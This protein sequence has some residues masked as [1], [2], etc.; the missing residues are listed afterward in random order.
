MKRIAVVLILLIAFIYGGAAFYFSDVIIHFHKRTLEEDRTNLKFQPVAAEFGLG[1]PEEASVTVPEHPGTDETI[2]LNGWYFAN[3][4]KCAVILHHGHTGTR[5]GGLKYVRL[6]AEAPY[7]CS[8]LTVDARYHGESEGSCGTYGYHESRDMKHWIDWLQAKTQLPK[9]QIGL[10]GESM[11]AAIV[12]ITAGREP[13]LA[14]VG[15]DAP[16]S[17]LQPIFYERG[18][19]DFGAAVVG[20]ILPP[21]MFLAGLRCNFQPA[22]VSP[23][24]A[25]AA[26]Q[27]P[28]F[29]SHS[30]ADA[31]T[32]PY[33]SEVIYEA[34]PHER[35]TLHINEWGARHGQDIFVNPAGYRENLHTFLQKYVPQFR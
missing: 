5:W 16:Y 12:L 30:L 17:D 31:G 20:P 25:A 8:V 35:K 7:R 24:A 6:F 15:A 27:A 4:G 9:S 34:V 2:T 3:S 29:L 18:S 32:K 1:P 14:F 22:E 19:A 33:H 28:V 11:G 26:I 13:E 21:A 10:M 23:R